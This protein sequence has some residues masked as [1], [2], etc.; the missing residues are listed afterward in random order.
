MIERA[1]WSAAPSIAFSHIMM[2]YAFAAAANECKQLTAIWRPTGITRYH[3]SNE[4]K[5]TK[6]RCFDIVLV[7]MSLGTEQSALTASNWRPPIDPRSSTLY[8]PRSSNHA[9]QPLIMSTTKNPAQS[10]YTM[11]ATRRDITNESLSPPSP[12]GH[13]PVMTSKVQ[14]QLIGHQA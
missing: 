13:W 3:R 10:L 11:R 2:L 1:T 8:K 7:N 9:L 5:Q 6:P 14:D 4:C 12:P